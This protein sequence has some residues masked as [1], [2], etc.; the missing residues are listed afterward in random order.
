ME[1]ININIDLGK[2]VEDLSI[3]DQQLVAICRSLN[4]ELKL[5]IMDEPTTALTS[6]EVDA[7]FKVVTDLQNKGISILFVSHKLNEVMQIAQR[8]TIL[9]D[10]KKT[11]CYPASDMDSR[12]IELLMTGENFQYKKNRTLVLREKP[13][14][15]VKNLSRKD[16]YKDI[17]FTLYPGEVLGITGPLGSGRTELALSFLE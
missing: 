16:N 3:A 11:G 17:S 10:G 1:K 7:L 14:L 9:K 13:L 4:G 5:L 2:R 8:V 6:R 15:E 12:K